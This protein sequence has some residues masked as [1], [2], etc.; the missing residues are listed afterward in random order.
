MKTSSTPSILK[1]CSTLPTSNPSALFVTPLLWLSGW[2]CHIC[3]I[4]LNDIM[5]LHIGVLV[6][7]G[8]CP[9][10]YATWSQVYWGL[11][12]NMVLL[13]VLWLDIIH[14][15]TSKDTQHKQGSRDWH[16]HV[17]IILAPPVLC[18]QQLSELHCINNL[19]ISKI[20]FT[21]FHNIFAF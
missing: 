21:E 2:S 13:L 7:E 14:S 17:N 1:F 10:F 4:L 16:N 5:D 12:H 15:H 19:L 9:V 8:P 6:P 3:F 20:Y 18:S 11:T